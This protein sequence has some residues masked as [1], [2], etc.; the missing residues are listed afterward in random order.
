MTGGAASADATQ[1]YLPPT[2][3]RGVSPDA[4]LMQ[5]EIFGPILPVI[6]VPSIDSAISFVNQR[7]KPLSLYVFTS[8]NQVAEQVLA[9][10]SSGS[11]CVNT[12]I[13]QLAVPGLPFGGVGESG[14][15]AYHGRRGFE[16]FSHNKA[17]MVKPTLPEP[18]LQYPP[19]SKLRQRLLR[20]IY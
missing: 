8:R 1:R 20:K 16:T 14:M 6:S 4:P 3:V 2:I 12:C 17:V 15:G 5:E 9:R 7:P 11:A 18:P 10:T 13:V 19:Y